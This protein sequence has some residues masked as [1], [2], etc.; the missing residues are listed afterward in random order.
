MTDRYR[1]VRSVLEYEPPPIKHSRFIARVGPARDE[2]EARELLDAMRRDYPDAR[3]VCWAWR[4]GLD[5]ATTR[6]SDDGEPGGSAGRPILQ[7]L[8]G[9]EVTCVAAAVARYFGGTKLGVG[10]LM[11]AYGGAAGMALDRADVHVVDVLDAVEC[12]HDYPDSSAV[13]GVLA[14]FGVEQEDAEYAEDVRFRVR[15]PRARRPEFE[16]L[17]RD[18]TGGR[19]GTSCNPARESD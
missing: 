2:A 19:G 15:I 13:G 11:R 4:L 5:G 9:H 17:F 10:G 14:A 6:S 3:H 18:A 8:E 1:T 7:Q 12:R 16:A